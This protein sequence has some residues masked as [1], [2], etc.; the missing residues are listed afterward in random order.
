[1]MKDTVEIYTAPTCPDCKAAKQF[2]SN[3]N[4]SFSDHDVSE[5]LEQDALKK[6]TGKQIVP[7]IKIG[8]KIFIGFA[9]NRKEIENLLLGS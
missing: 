7:T 9:A 2:L 6:L 5:Q 4:I 1:M 8:Q 3:H